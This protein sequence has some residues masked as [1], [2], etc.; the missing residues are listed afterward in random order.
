MRHPWG[1][2]PPPERRCDG[3]I[4]HVRCPPPAGAATPHVVEECWSAFPRPKVVRGGHSRRPNKGEKAMSLR[5]TSTSVIG[6]TMILAFGAAISLAQA[7][8]KSTKRIPISKEAGGEVV[9]VDTVVR[10]DT[11][12]VTNYRT[13]TLYRTVHRVDT[14]V[15]QPP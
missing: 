13:D 4:R 3:Q 6:A 7:N 2:R 5:S 11:V 15:V 14:V 1:L 9:R 10:S 12:T 8:P